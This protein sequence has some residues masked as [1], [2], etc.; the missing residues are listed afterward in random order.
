MVGKQFDGR[1]YHRIERVSLAVLGCLMRRFLNVAAN[2]FQS[3]PIVGLATPAISKYH[4]GGGIYIF[5]SIFS[6]LS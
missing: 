5:I 1:V 6:W 3:F 4:T 2:F